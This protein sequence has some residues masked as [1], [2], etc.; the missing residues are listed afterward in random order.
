[1]AVVSSF[2]GTSRQGEGSEVLTEYEHPL[3]PQYGDKARKLGGQNPALAQCLIQCML[4][5]TA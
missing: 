1:V 4:E 2:P 5:G 3:W